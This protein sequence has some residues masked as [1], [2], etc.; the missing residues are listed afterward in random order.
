VG[1]A[2]E[3]ASIALMF[4]IA[5]YLHEIKQITRGPASSG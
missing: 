2:G 1:E 4:V 3:L 5:L